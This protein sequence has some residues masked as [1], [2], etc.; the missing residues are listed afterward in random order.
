ME[1]LIKRAQKGD[2]EAFIDAVKEYMPQLY[3]VAKTKLR[4]DEDAGDAIQDTIL[5]AFSNL[6]KLKEPRYFKTWIIKVLMNK[7]NDIVKRSSKFVY[8]G[9]YNE[10]EEKNSMPVISENIEDELDFKN[11][12]TVLND[13]HRIVIILFYIN[14]FTTREISEIL[15]EKE[16]TIKS[17]LRRARYQLREYYV[18]DNN[19]VSF[20]PGGSLK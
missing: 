3:N 2:K 6:K 20:N 18:K 14:G 8:V 10:V 13:D 17:R 1:E 11:L 5:A 4:N 9:D 12:L 15:S 7:C 19:I 16:G